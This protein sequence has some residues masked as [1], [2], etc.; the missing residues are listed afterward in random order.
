MQAQS[1]LDGLFIQ[2]LGHVI[3]GVM[4]EQVQLGWLLLNEQFIG[5]ETFGTPLD[6]KQLQ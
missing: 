6:E 5:H 2:S 1:L 3:W 4:L